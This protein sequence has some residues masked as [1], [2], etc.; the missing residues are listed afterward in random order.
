MD[1]LFMIISL[2][3]SK[4]KILGSLYRFWGQC[5]QWYICKK[6]EKGLRNIQR[7]WRNYRTRPMETQYKAGFVQNH[8]FQWFAILRQ[9]CWWTYEWSTAWWKV[10]RM[11]NFRWE[12]SLCLFITNNVKIFRQKIVK[13]SSNNRLKNR[14][15]IGTTVWWKMHR[16]SN[17]RRKES[18][19]LFVKKS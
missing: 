1:F 11:S 15:K 6:P 17:F 12:E 13:K 5:V 10:H 2:F 16:M 19:C 14:Q 7:H 8:L 18:L 3:L 4:S 9:L